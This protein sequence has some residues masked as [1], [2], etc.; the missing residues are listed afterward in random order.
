MEMKENFRLILLYLIAHLEEERKK[1][2]SNCKEHVIQ[3]RKKKLRRRRN[4]AIENVNS[5]FFG[6]TAACNMVHGVDATKVNRL[7]PLHDT[8]QSCRSGL[9]DWRDPNPSIYLKILLC[10]NI[11]SIDYS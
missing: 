2:E 6:S 7:D 8:N 1:N 9:K 11:F 10:F 4:K 5:V 3:P